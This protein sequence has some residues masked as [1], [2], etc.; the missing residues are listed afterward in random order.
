M[1]TYRVSTFVAVPPERV[2]EAWTD[3]D[4]F[5]EWIGGV[6]RVTDR[7]GSTDQA[8]SSYTV[9]FGRMA[10]PTVVIAAER[11]RHIRTKFGNAILKGESD[12]TFTPEGGGTRIQQVFETRGLV[13]TVV[14]RL[15][16]TGSYRGSFRAELETFRA[17]VE[18]DSPQADGN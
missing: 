7:V 9:W 4:R 11:P 15:F 17:M 5:T 3:P 14:G 18:R 10:S 13:A 8:G 16:A 1:A 12:V 2:F 6:T